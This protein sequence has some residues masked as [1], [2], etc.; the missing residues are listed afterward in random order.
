MEALVKAGL[1]HTPGKE[2]PD[3]SRLPSGIIAFT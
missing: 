2:K 3:R 1:L